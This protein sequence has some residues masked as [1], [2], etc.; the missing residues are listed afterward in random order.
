MGPYKF[1]RVEDEDSR[2]EYVENAG[3]W[4]ENTATRV[5]F[6]SYD[7]TLF[8]QVGRHLDW[9]NREPTP[10]IS[11]YG[12]KDVAEREANRR[13]RD[14]KQNVRVYTI[15]MR[16]L[17][18][19]QCE[20]RNARRLADKLRLYIPKHAWNNSKYEYICLHHVPQVAIIDRED[21]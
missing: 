15:N 16:M 2:A 4:A 8:E 7:E 19:N 1:Y 17:E 20:Y 10:F 11:M 3:L 9:A 6:R 12:D 18:K 21:Y 13:V 5:D 14:G